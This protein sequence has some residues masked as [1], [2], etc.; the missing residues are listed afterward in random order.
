MKTTRNV[1][2]SGLLAAGMAASVPA[3]DN[4]AS[5]T[6]TEG[7]VGERVRLVLTERPG[8]KADAP[9]RLRG[10]VVRAD[11]A[12][13]W[14]RTAD[15]ETAV[16]ALDEVERLQISRGR[17]SRGRGAKVG[18][19]SGAVAGLAL[20]GVAFAAC[21]TEE[22]YDNSLCRASALYSLIG[23]TAVAAAVGAGIGAAVPPSERWESVPDQGLRILVQP[24]PRGASASVAVSF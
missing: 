24:R 14:V 7:L 2:F 18:A 17:H 1:L 20:G 16:V 15:A 9:D 6:G 11:G 13:L 8:G 23:V 22:Q 4:G 12:Q 5:V 10:T 3:A 19:V 21:G